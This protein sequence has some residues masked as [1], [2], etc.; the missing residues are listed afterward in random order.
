MFIL[1]VRINI[2]ILGTYQKSIEGLITGTKNDHVEKDDPT[3]QRTLV[4]DTR[5]VE[6]QEV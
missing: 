4:L 3:I 2:E 5:V 1:I 6:P